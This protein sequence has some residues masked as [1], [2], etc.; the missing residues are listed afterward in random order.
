MSTHDPRVVEPDDD[1]L[2]VPTADPFEPEAPAHV[3]PDEETIVHA[4]DPDEEAAVD[5]T[6]PDPRSPAEN[7]A[8]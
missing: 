6:P 1:N 2:T 7:D 5:E 4:L 3:D 8:L